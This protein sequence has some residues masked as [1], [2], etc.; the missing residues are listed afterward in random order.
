[1]LPWQVVHNQELKAALQKLS[2]DK[3]L[4]RLPRQAHVDLKKVVVEAASDRSRSPAMVW[5]LILGG[6]AQ[7][8]RSTGMRE[9]CVEQ[10]RG[11]EIA[12]AFEAIMN[13]A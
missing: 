5:A 10:S 9:W 12:L 8:S 6:V 7:D 3:R 4:A 1:M 13:G 11:D 2:N